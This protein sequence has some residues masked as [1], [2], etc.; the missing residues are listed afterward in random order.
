MLFWFVLDWLTSEILF[1]PQ[2]LKLR[3]AAGRCSDTQRSVEISTT[4]STA[5]GLTACSEPLETVTSLDVLRRRVLE[6]FGM[7]LTFKPKYAISHIYMPQYLRWTVVSWEWSVFSEE[8]DCCDWSLD[9]QWLAYEA[10]DSI[11]G[12][13]FEGSATDCA[14]ETESFGKDASTEITEPNET[15]MSLSIT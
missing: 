12:S 10:G 5:A 1:F 9:R 2:E 3:L 15:I 7:Q 6:S 11:A 4:S 14:G 13:N 8:I